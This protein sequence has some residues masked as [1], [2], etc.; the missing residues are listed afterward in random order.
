MWMKMTRPAA[1]L[2]GLTAA[3]LVLASPGAWAQ[4]GPSAQEIVDKMLEGN[5]SLGF[6]SGR[7]QLS[8]LIE[9]KTGD[10]R[11]RSLDVKS[12]RIQGATRTVVSLT[13]PKEVKGQAFLFAENKAGEDDVWMFL[14]AFKVTRRVEGSNKKGAFLGSHFTFADLESRD[15]KDSAHARLPDESIGKDAVF[16]I[17]SSPKAP[18]QSDYGKVVSFVRKSDYLPLKVRFYDKDGKTEL[19][20]IFVERL[21]KNAQGK[22]YVKQMTLRAKTG[23]FT[24]IT[25]NAL[26]EGAE[27]PDTIFAK[28]QLG[29]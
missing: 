17:E 23:G 24:T 29:K 4:E 26:D 16:V 5:N 6:Q 27:L 13:E 12:K 21:E 15:V 2:A 22:T 7:A 20:T 14:P 18:G 19:K 9:D 3:A 10:Q 1:W 28:E 11:A 8:L 25:I